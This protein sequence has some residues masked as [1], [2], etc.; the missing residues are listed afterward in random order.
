[1]TGTMKHV[2]NIDPFY[3]IQ[4]ITV[5]SDQYLYKQ[6]AITWHGQQEVSQTLGRSTLPKVAYSEKVPG[7]L[8]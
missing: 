1:M 2:K 4:E 7:E 8:L 3:A 6:I 5:R